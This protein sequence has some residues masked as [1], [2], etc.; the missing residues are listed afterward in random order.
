MRGTQ[1]LNCHASWIAALSWPNR[2]TTYLYVMWGHFSCTLAILNA[3][4]NLAKHEP[5]C[6]SHVMHHIVAVQYLVLIAHFS[7]FYMCLFL[8]DRRR[9]REERAGVWLPTL[10]R[11]VSALK[12]SRVRVTEA[13]PLNLYPRGADREEGEFQPPPAAQ[14]WPRPW[15]SPS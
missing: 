7:F 9:F 14:W 11:I 6:T 3:P 2:F 12:R 8:P 15:L 4:L 10:R 13:S 5:S 1:I